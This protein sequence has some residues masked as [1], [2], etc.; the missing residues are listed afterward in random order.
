L[1]TPASRFGR[2]E[3]FN[4][5]NIIYNF[6]LMLSRDEKTYVFIPG[7]WHG[8]WVFDPVTQSLGAL[9]KK[10]FSL[11]L[12]GLELEPVEENRIINLN[13]HIQFVIDFL[14]EENISDVILCGHSYG[15]MVITGVAD[16]IPARIRSLVYIDAYVPKNGD[17]C[18]KLTSEIYRQLF[19]T[20]AGNDGFRVAVPPG[21]ENRRRPH[22]L[23]TFMQGIQ[24]T[25]NYEQIL[26]RTFI[27]LSGWEGTP[28]T[29]QYER[30]KDSQDWHI[31]IINCGHN[32]MRECPERLTN[33]LCELEDRYKDSRSNT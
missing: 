8:G 15:G 31:E 1:S 28:F 13:T 27:Y 22:P 10:C 17:S 30:L 16:Q 5:G 11:T 29:N 3:L 12:P 4:I 14:L 21:I 26:N 19:V 32:V 23:A 7:G 6:T 24:L 20:G 18:W 2:T 33:I 9:K 25:G